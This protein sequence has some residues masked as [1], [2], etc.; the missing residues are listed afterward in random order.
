MSPPKKS[1]KKGKKK[2]KKIPDSQAGNFFQRD[3]WKGIWEEEEEIR[4]VLVGE[5][6]VIDITSMVVTV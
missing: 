1:K 6:E 3:I 4:P 2:T 5:K